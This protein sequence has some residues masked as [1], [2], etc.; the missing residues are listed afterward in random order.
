MALGCTWFIQRCHRLSINHLQVGSLLRVVELS[1]QVWIF[2]FTIF[3][4]EQSQSNTRL[5][6]N[7]HLE[8]F[9]VEESKQVERECDEL[10]YR[11]RSQSREWQT[12]K[13]SN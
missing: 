11:R 7:E 2:Q 1:V 9:P 8:M 5:E 13:I 10:S 12:R 4:L 6:Q 3:Q